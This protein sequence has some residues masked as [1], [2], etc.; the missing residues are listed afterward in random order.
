MA[1]WQP[2]STVHVVRTI[3]DDTG[4]LADA[5][6]LPTGAVYLNGAIDNAV[7]V[8][9]TN[10]A[11]GRYRLSFTVPSGYAL[12]DDVALLLLAT[13]GGIGTGATVW[14]TRL[15]AAPPT[16]AEVQTQMEGGGSSLA[17]LITTLANLATA[18]LTV[19]EWIILAA[20]TSGDTELVN[21]VAKLYRRSGAQVATES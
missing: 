9:V 15:T 11:T 3:T 7:T 10:L 13:V 6:S 8:T 17:S 16:A 5:D 14:E 1:D 19:T 18:D 21:G 4:A 20:A 2:G 12:G